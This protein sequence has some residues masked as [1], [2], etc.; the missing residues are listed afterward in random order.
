[1][2]ISKLINKRIK[3][4]EIK[5]PVPVRPAKMTVAEGRKLY[6]EDYAETHKYSDV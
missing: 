5:Y 4:P 2:S 6:L 3:V 1:M